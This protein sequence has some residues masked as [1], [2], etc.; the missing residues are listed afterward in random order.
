[1]YKNIPTLNE[2][3]YVHITGYKP[4]DSGEYHLRGYAV[5][6]KGVRV[7]GSKTKTKR[8]KSTQELTI[9]ERR[10][11]TA[12][13]NDLPV[14]RSKT[15]EKTTELDESNA[16]VA[17]YFE[18]CDHAEELLSSWKSP[19]TRKKLLAIFENQVLPFI[20]AFETTVFTAADRAELENHMI[21]LSGSS[22][23]SKG[24][25]N[26]VL[27]TVRGNLHAAQMILEAMRRVNPMLMAID[28]EP[29]RVKKIVNEQ[30]KSLTRTVRREFAR[31]LRQ[32]VKTEPRMVLG[33]VLMWCAGLR[34]AEAAAIIPDLDVEK[35]S[36]T[37]TIVKVF[38]QS[39]NGI[40]SKI[41]KTLNSYRIV[42]LDFWARTMI[43]ACNA[44]IMATN[45]EDYQTMYDPKNLSK[46]VRRLLT[47]CGCGQDF[48]ATAEEE[49]RKNPGDDSDGNV[50][51]DIS[52]YVLRRDAASTWRNICGL[53]NYDC[54]AMLGH[55]D[56]RQK[57][58]K[59]DYRIDSVLLAIADKLERFVRDS[60]ISAHPGITP[61][62]LYHGLDFKTDPY[63][64]MCFK[65]ES[66]KPLSVRGSILAAEAGESVYI[67]ADHKLDITIK[68]YTK[69]SIRNTET[70]EKQFVPIIGSN[71]D[72][73][74]WQEGGEIEEDGEAIS[75]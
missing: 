26:T 44:R 8:A 6:E 36:E 42:P 73:F 38:W 58:Q 30:K 14:K 31:K 47:D 62:M 13:V 74:C 50:I 59:L 70:G 1:M 15:R 66:G 19:E 64:E 27:N 34:T 61:I 16:W 35:R 68:V 60:E 33:A 54:D 43:E 55:A 53:S 22:A 23:K 67:I 20:S 2:N 69:T 52:A 39:K 71:E 57:K 41:L 75:I 4:D 29:A 37:L 65:N 40:R 32:L 24:N 51:Y 49:E 46:W 56:K 3:I 18:V 72:V 9:I 25:N 5:D 11:V 28:V 17:A 45:P 12:I 63:E 7:D 21:Q 48:W 10:L